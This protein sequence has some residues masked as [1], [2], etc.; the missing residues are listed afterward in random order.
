MAK[1]FSQVEQEVLARYREGVWNRLRWWLSP[2]WRHLA[3]LDAIMQAHAYVR[4]ME[5]RRWIEE[6]DDAT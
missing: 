1:T 5:R 4:Q 6:M 3:R 2:S